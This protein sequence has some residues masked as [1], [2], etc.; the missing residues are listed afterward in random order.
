[1]ILEITDLKCSYGDKEV[2]KGVT[3]TARPRVTALIGPNAAGKTTLM[4]CIAGILQS[5]GKMTLDGIDI[6]DGRDRRTRE[7]MSYLPQEAPDRTSLTVMEIVLLGRLDSL[8]WK[9]SEEDL[10]AAY[11]MLV[12]LGIEDLAIRPMNELSGGQQQLV[13]IAQCLVRNPRVLLMDEPTNSLDLQKQLEMF[14]LIRQVTAE[15]AMT[16]L[17]VLHDINFAARYADRVIV[18]SEG[19]VHSAGPPHEVINE[20]MIREVYGVESTVEMG[21]DLVPSVRP[22]RSVRPFSRRHL[23][24]DPEPVP[25]RCASGTSVAGGGSARARLDTLEGADGAPREGWTMKDAEAGS[26]AHRL[27]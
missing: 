1:L 19:A 24:V 20:A 18:L 3:L 23:C 26:G 25:H 17:M 2:L 4:R 14:D 5:S 16:T 10:S 9:V 22:L 7:T 8:T 21:P 6:T 27:K 13:M 15:K 12:E 11:G